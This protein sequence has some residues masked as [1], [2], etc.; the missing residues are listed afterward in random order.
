[1]ATL[2]ELFKSRKS[3][4]YGKSEKIR[5][6]SLGLINPPR[7]AALLASSPNALAD[8]I[9]GQIG[10]ALGGSANRPT[11]TIFKSD[12]FLSKPIS[13]FKTRQQLRDAVTPDTP[14]Y[15]KDNP[16]PAS[17]FAAYKQGASS[18]MDMAMNLA[19]DA[20]NSVGG[21][22]NKGNDLK[23]KLKERNEAGKGYG[24][25]YTRLD[26]GGKPLTETHKFSSKGDTKGWF[27]VYTQEGDIWYRSAIKE[28]EP[29]K[30]TTWDAANADILK[31]EK[32]DTLTKFEEK[33]KE[34]QFAN[35]A[36]IGFKKYGTNEVIPFVGTITGI[37][38]DITPEWTDF[39]YVGS[40]YKIYKY[41]GVERSLKFELKLYYT[42]NE[43]KNIMI[44]KIN[45]LKS[46]VFPFD[47][48]TTIQYPGVG[49]EP[50]HFSPNLL[51]LTIT[52]MYKNLLGIVDTLS[53]SIDDNTTWT[54]FNI[55]MED[56]KDNT[57]YPNV[58]N[59]SF[60]MRIIENHKIDEGTKMYKYDFDGNNSDGSQ[61][62]KTPSV[63]S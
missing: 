52:G 43:E 57:I 8:L 29:N 48:L 16:S 14:Y 39:K 44:K 7:G 28:R 35:Q 58:I 60:G 20:L 22:K 17:L 62:I 23:N 6:D 47:E 63:K 19:K 26:I 13:L 51:H 34:H 24:T 30:H 15:V 33:L 3:E 61:Y 27:P 4:L 54:N 9:G 18:P 41:N 12:G 10:G 42:T 11:D 37:S 5:I 55:N 32:F 21:K 1:M 46:L 53:F 50:L 45:F 40:P 2:Q 56:G 25:R 49:Y 38:E 31:T 59:V 36:W